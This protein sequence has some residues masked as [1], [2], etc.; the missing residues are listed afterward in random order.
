MSRNPTMMTPQL[1][2]KW[3]LWNCLMQSAKLAYIITC[4]DRSI[5]IQMALY[6][7]GRLPINSVNL[8]RHE[9]GLYLIKPAENRIVTYTLQ[10][11]HV[12]NMFDKK[13][14][15]DKSGALDFALLKYKRPHW[16]VKVSVNDNEIPDY[17]EAGKL[18]ESVGLTWGGRFKHPDL[19]HLQT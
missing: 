16:D 11:R 8:F 13:L 9:A 14:D 4:V 6:T 3:Q 1:Y 19:C 7:M 2:S 12:T 17:E 18:A 10:S 15:N 5:L